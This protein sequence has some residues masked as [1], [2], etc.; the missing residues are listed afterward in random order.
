VVFFGLSLK[1]FFFKHSEGSE[2]ATHDEDNEN[3]ISF[4]QCQFP[5]TLS[6]KDDDVSFSQRHFY[7]LIKIIAQV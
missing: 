3:S 6:K 1:V 7:P 5:F 4:L 2:D